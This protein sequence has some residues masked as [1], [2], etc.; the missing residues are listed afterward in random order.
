MI[1]MGDEEGCASLREEQWQGCWGV[2]TF[3]TLFGRQTS[4]RD[5]KGNLGGMG[6]TM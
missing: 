3:L 5:Y 6:A 2:T 4:N 1:M